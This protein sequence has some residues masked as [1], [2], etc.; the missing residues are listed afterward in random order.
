[1]PA[2]DCGNCE[3]S[4]RAKFFYG[5]FC[6]CCGIQGLAVHTVCAVLY[7][8]LSVGRFLIMA[9][10]LTSLAEIAAVFAG[11]EI[12]QKYATTSG[13]F[14]GYDQWLNGVLFLGENV[15]LSTRDLENVLFTRCDKVVPGLGATNLLLLLLL[16]LL[17]ISEFWSF[18]TQFLILPFFC[19]L[20]CQL[21]DNFFDNFL[22]TF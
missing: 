9:A 1:M 16:L 7:C 13:R 10:K 20:F 3:L 14:L 21:F 17:P 6:S 5:I 22:T 15:L 4:K 18:Y 8:P 11:P 2:R 12:R 19:Q